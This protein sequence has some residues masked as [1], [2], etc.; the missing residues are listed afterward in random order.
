MP[1]QCPTKRLMDAFS[2]S[3]FTSKMNRLVTDPCGLLRELGA[4]AFCELDWPRGRL[5][6]I[7]ASRAADSE[8]HAD[9]R[10]AQ[11]RGRPRCRGRP[12]LRPPPPPRTLA[13]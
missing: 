10:D 4:E 8:R 2:Q 9:F 1:K 7:I 3:E 5:G 13:R 6:S 11:Q 12:L